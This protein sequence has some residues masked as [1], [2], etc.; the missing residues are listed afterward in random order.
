MKSKWL[1]VLSMA[2]MAV[3]SASSASAQPDWTQVATT[4]PAGRQDAAMAYCPPTGKIVMFGGH[5]GNW[6]ALADTWEWDGTTWSLQ[7][8]AHPPPGA[9]PPPWPTTPTTTR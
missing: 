2:V 5:T 8:P 1:C 7:S 3:L 4:G 9:S 6:S